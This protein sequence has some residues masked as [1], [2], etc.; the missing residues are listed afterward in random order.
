M[1]T[2]PAILAAMGKG[3]VAGGILSPPTTFKAQS[4][5]FVELINTVKLGDPLTHAGAKSDQPYGRGAAYLTA[6]QQAWTY[7]ANSSN[8]TQVANPDQ[9]IDNSIIQ[10]AGHSGH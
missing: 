4:R 2:V 7:Y 6:C 3:L 10:A 8:K 9:F 5:G 1:R